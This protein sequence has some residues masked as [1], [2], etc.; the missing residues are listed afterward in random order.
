MISFKYILDGLVTAGV[1]VEELMQSYNRAAV[2][3]VDP[4]SEYHTLSTIQGDSQFGG[5]DGYHPEVKIFT[6]DKIKV[7]F[8]TLSEGDVKYLLPDGT[9]DKMLHFLSQAFRSLNDRLRAEGR[10]D[11]LY[12]YHDLRDEV[13]R[14]QYGREGDTGDGGN[15]SSIQGLLWRLDSR[16]DTPD[17]IF[18]SQG[19]EVSS[20]CAHNFR[21]QHHGIP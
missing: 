7:R 21:S 16:F 1:L 2:L 20:F 14:Q 13:Q 19:I 4:H 11:Y 3:I 9:S 6:P 10:R 8:S 18:H 5:S 12:N 17:G 15:V